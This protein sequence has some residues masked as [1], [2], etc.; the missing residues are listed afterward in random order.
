MQAL[1]RV[2]ALAGLEKGNTGADP[3]EI[4]GK[5]KSEDE[6]SEA[7]KDPVGVMARACMEE[8]TRRNTGDPD[9]RDV[10]PLAAREGEEEPGRAGRRRGT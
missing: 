2:N 8:E 4:R 9:D 7:S 3:A 5:R 6:M 10:S 1:T